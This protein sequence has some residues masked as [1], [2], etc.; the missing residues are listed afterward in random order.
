M[1]NDG[2]SY[3][4]EYDRPFEFKSFLTHQISK[5]FF[6]NTTWVFGSGRPITLPENQY[7]DFGEDERT[8]LIYG[9]KNT[10]CGRL[11]AGL[12]MGVC[13]KKLFPNG[14]QANGML[15]TWTS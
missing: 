8:I 10:F 2:K 6:F 7:Y 3:P 1:V 15:V 13:T 9:E 11:P 14:A 5:K 12:D 4:Y